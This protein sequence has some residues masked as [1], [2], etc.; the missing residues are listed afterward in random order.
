L[1]VPAQIPALT[2]ETVG[3]QVH[4]SWPDPNRVYYLQCSTGDPAN[5]WVNIPD[6]PMLMNG[7]ATVILPKS[8]TE[9]RFYRLYL[10]ISW[11]RPPGRD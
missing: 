2:I 10:G 3:L 4:I 11:D 6:R 8:E 5:E 1:A 7:I 9:H